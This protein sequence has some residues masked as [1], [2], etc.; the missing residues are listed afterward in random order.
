MQIYQILT[1]SI[2]SIMVFQGIIKYFRKTSHYTILKLLTQIIV[3]GGIGLVIAY[4][5]TSMYKI[6]DF[7]GIKE[8]F[9]ALILVGFMLVL[10]LI[11]KLL[12]VIENLEKNINKIIRQEALRELK[13]K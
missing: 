4:P 5:E 1:I 7:L 6:A 12:A 10:I 9:N 8:G 11:F 13:N 2:S 3:W